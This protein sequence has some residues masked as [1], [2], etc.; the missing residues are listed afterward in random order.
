MEKV[1]KAKV[2]SERGVERKRRLRGLGPTAQEKCQAVLSIWTERRKPGEVCREMGVAW[3]ILKQWQDRAME[4]N[5]CGTVAPRASGEGGGLE[6]PSCS[7]IGEKKPI[8]DDEGAGQETEETARKPE[9]P[10]GTAGGCSGEK[11]LATIKEIPDGEG[12]KTS[13]GAGIDH[14]PGTERGLNRDGGGGALEG[15]AQD[16]LRVGGSGPESHGSG[17][18]ETCSR[19]AVCSSGCGEGGAPKASPGS[20][21]KVVPG[22]ED[23]RGERSS[24]GIRSS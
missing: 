16:L 21:E 22:G 17:V 14:P 5:V 24:F 1:E 11:A 3:G 4:G 12:E 2:E 7:I 19:E 8:G 13:A 6:P 18:G 9:G 15:V 20:G 23:D 10:P